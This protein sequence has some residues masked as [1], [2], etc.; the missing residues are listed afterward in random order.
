MQLSFEGEIRN[1][2]WNE[3]HGEFSGVFDKSLSLKH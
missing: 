1:W 3:T 2:D